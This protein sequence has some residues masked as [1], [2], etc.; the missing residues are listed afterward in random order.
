MSPNPIS[1]VRIVVAALFLAI[2]ILSLMT[3]LKL[4]GAIGFSTERRAR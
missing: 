1:N 3:A 4:D 2:G